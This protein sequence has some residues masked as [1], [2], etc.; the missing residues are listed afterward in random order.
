[1]LKLTPPGP[2]EKIAHA[3]ATGREVRP[4][5]VFEAVADA[6]DIPITVTVEEEDDN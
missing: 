2:L 6:L 3:F 4:G 1:V 5:E